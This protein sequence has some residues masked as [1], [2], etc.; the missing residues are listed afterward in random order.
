MIDHGLEPQTFCVL[1]KRDKPTTPI[2]RVVTDRVEG[3]TLP[4]NHRQ[5]FKFL[6]KCPACS[7]VSDQ[8]CLPTR[9]YRG[10]LGSDEREARPRE[11]GSWC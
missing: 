8:H 9:S 1:G 5:A 11:D 10:V 3:A 4:I 7:L 6:E 2:D